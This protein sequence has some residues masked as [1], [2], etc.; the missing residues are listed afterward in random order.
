MDDL[1]FEGRALKPYGEYVPDDQLIIG[2]FF[3][4]EF[5]TPQVLGR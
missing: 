5:I 4:C 1:Y 2:E 3:A